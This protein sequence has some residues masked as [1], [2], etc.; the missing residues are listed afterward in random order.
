[1]HNEMIHLG[2]DLDNTIIC[3][4]HVFVN[5]AKSMNIIPQ[6]YMGSKQSLKQFIFQKFLDGEII[7]Q[8]LQGQIYGK[9]IHEARVYD[10]FFPFLKKCLTKPNMKISIVSHKTI[11]G[12]MDPEKIN[13]RK[14]ALDWLTD[15]QIIG[16][17]NFSSEN[18]FFESSREEK[19]KK[20]RDLACTHFVDDLIEVFSENMF[21][22]K[23][24]KFLFSP[25]GRNY[26]LNLSGMKIERYL[27]WMEI[28]NA[29][30]KG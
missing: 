9:Y 16:Y 14:A 10:G 27:T 13:L 23:I 20:I 8:Q 4:D 6:D 12:H 21:P 25:N 19:V 18:V 17:E 29:L 1:M 15:N 3:Y 22:K 2:L 26:E 24:K 7:W 30:F 28:E 5:V 11:Y